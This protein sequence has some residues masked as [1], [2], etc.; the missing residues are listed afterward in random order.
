[1]CRL[2]LFANRDQKLGAMALLRMSKGLDLVERRLVQVDVLPESGHIA[3]LLADDLRCRVLDDARAV[4]VGLVRCADEILRRLADAPDAGIAFA[5]GAEELDDNARQDGGLQQRP[6]L[7][8]KDNAWPAGNAGCPVSCCMS[9]EQAHRA[10][11]PRI[12]LQLLH[13]EVEPGII[14][15]DGCRSI[16]ESGIRPLIHPCA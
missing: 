10:F 11:Q 15:F 5:G 16:K 2:G 13:V 8:E 9:N 6:A 14:Q 1:M 4:L 12:V 3:R 7:I